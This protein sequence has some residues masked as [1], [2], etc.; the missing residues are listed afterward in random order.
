MLEDHPLVW[1]MLRCSI[2][3]IDLMLVME[4]PEVFM[5]FCLHLCA[6]KREFSNHVML[7]AE[8]LN[9]YVFF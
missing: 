2:T 8:P 6:A 7:V 1:D 3:S 4:H 5:I 9:G